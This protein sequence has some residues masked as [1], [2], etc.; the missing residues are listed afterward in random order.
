MG[1]AEA[2]MKP[3]ATKTKCALFWHRTHGQH[4]T[5]RGWGPLGGVSPP[6]ILG[7]VLIQPLRGV[8]R[9]ARGCF[10]VA[11]TR[12]MKIKAVPATTWGPK[13][14]ILRP[15]LKTL[16]GGSTNSSTGQWR[17]ATRLRCR[18][19]SAWRS[20]TPA[21]PASSLAF[22]SGLLGQLLKRRLAFS[23]WR[24]LRRCG[25][26]SAICSR[27]CAVA[28]LERHAEALFP[29]SNPTHSALRLMAG[30]LHEHR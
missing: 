24:A 5:A 28:R 25:V 1:R 4:G 9:Q 16:A 13:C 29:P 17:A 3:R 15:L 23:R 8:G 20:S 6:A 14:K 22:A 10:T 19:R 21:P 26:P 27:A 7:A 11:K 2:N 12:F 18:R 30:K